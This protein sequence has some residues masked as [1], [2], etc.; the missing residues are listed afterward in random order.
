MDDLRRDT[1]EQ[2]AP[3][4]PEPTR[5]D[6]DQ[7]D[8]AAPCELQDRVC[9]RPLEQLGVIRHVPF[10]GIGSRL[11]ERCPHRAET[12]TQC[13]LV[14]RIAQYRQWCVCDRDEGHAGAELLGE[15]DAFLCS[16][17]RSW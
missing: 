16:H 4:R 2:G 17:E 9:G 10:L 13:A 11:G 8:V 12:L 7:I 14:V 6:D 3:D 15:P 5:A 1:A